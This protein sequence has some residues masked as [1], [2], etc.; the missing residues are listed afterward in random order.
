LILNEIEQIPKILKRENDFI[1]VVA[2]S[3]DL[4]RCPV[5]QLFS[6]IYG[7]HLPM[8]ICLYLGIA[9]HTAV[10]NILHGIN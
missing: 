10:K 1:K 5:E 4:G 3:L 7:Y 9:Y 2:A 6:C 8:H